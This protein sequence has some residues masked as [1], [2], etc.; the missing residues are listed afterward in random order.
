M[1]YI[2][3]QYIFAGL[4]SAVEVVVFNRSRPKV[5]STN[6]NEGTTVTNYSCC[7]GH[8]LA[9]DGLEDAPNCYNIY[10]LI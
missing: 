8:I 2:G 10:V 9:L 6:I 5:L 1:A 3:F 7:S 4:V